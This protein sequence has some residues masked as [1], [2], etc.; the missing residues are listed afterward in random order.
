MSHQTRRALLEAGIELVY[1]QPVPPCVSHISLAVVARKA[2][3]STGAAYRVWPTQDEFRR[4]LAVAAIAFRD[5]ASIANIVDDVRDLVDARA[6]FLEV[7]RRGGERH[8]SDR[9]AISETVT[10]L[11]LRTTSVHDEVTSTAAQ[12]RVA[13]GIAEHSNLYSVLMP[14]YGLKMRD[15]FTITHLARAIAAVAEG[16]A[17]QATE[18]A[19]HPIVDRHDL[20]EGVGTEWTLL[21]VTLQAIFEFFT[22]SASAASA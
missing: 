16:L 17:L 11:A 14:I 3:F 7:L 5:R 20:D 13:D 4:D 21:A 22:E 12:A 8:I 9:R 6:P 1:E 15:P 19:S 10:L 18:P 2:G